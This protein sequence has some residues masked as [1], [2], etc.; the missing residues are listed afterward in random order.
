M[1]LIP[2]LEPKQPDIIDPN[3]FARMAPAEGG[4][5][6]H[7]TASIWHD[8][9]QATTS[10]LLMGAQAYF[11]RPFQMHMYSGFKNGVIAYCK[12]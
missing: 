7:G 4:W 8:L 3:D 11:L 9:R 10:K 5:E 6:T 2:A 1:F 12:P